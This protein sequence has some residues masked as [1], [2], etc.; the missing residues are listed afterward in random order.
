[1]KQP[2]EYEI[3]GKEDVVCRLTKSIYGLKQAANVWNERL[4]KTLKEH[5]FIRSEADPCLYFKKENNKTIYIVVYVD[6]LFIT[7][8]T[9]NEIQLI[10]KSLNEH[11]YLT[12]LGFFKCYLG[13]QIERKNNSFFLRQEKYIEKI[14][15]EVGLEDAKISKMPLN[16]GY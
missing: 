3:K 13:I 10:A 9:E 6:I 12:D 4:D 5:C 15:K 11:S 2:E 7:G 1:M 8:E 16:P 14:L